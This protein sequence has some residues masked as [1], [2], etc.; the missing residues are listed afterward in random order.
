MKAVE[1]GY[2]ER[3]APGVSGVLLGT[4]AEHR[5]TQEMLCQEYALRSDRIVY[6][7]RPKDEKHP[8]LLP[9][10]EEAEFRIAKDRMYLRVP[11]IDDKER[12]YF[13]TSMT[14]RMDVDASR[15]AGSGTKSA[16]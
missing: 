14:P 13:V 5:K 9:I 11:E 8:R 4:D 10:G 6:R 3:G 2:E 7:V 1:C 12:Q 16:K 15:S